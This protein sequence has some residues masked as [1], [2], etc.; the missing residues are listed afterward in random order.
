[1]RFTEKQ[2]DVEEQRTNLEAT[3]KRFAD[4]GE[5]LIRSVMPAV[6]KLG[7][8]QARQLEALIARVVGD[9]TIC[10]HEGLLTIRTI[11]GPVDEL[12]E[13]KRSVTGRGI[14][15]GLREDITYYLGMANSER[16]AMEHLEPR[17]ELRPSTY[18][19]ESKDF[20]K[21]FS[22]T[23]HGYWES[24]CEMFARAFACYVHDKLEDMGVIC[25]YAVGHAESGPVPRGEERERLNADFDALIAEFKDRG[26]F[27]DYVEPELAPAGRETGAVQLTLDG[28]I[29]DAEGRAGEQAAGTGKE[30]EL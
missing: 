1:M 28:L 18:Y 30:Q 20:G 24:E 11:A 9:R 16:E 25:D 15:K 19:Q 22:K 7:P 4:Y 13:F 21:K 6:A 10:C 29:A 2:V 14:P 17:T 27:H 23:D 12:S 26:L 5:R 3:A 8:E